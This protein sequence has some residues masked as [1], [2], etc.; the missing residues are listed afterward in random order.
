LRR[1]AD[2]LA[3]IGSVVPGP[4]VEVNTGGMIRGKASSPYPSLALAAMLAERG[5]KVTIN[6]DAHSSATI[7][8]FYDVALD[9]LRAAGYGSIQVFQGHGES[10]A[11]WQEEGILC[12]I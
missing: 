12:T 11:V 7:D 10:G 4:G 8:G 9:L 5:V 6:A 3:G 2:T 1:V